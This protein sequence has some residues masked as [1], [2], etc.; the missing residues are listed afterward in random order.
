MK[1]LSCFLGLLLYSGFAHA[2]GTGAGSSPL[3]KKTNFCSFNEG[4]KRYY[5]IGATGRSLRAEDVKVYGDDFN[6][7]RKQA[8]NLFCGWPKPEQIGLIFNGNVLVDSEEEYNKQ[9]KLEHKITA[10]VDMGKPHTFYPEIKGPRKIE[11]T[12]RKDT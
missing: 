8:A 10:I 6:E 1:L 11:D 9:L 7:I 12:E 3:I 2:A 5:R 4:G